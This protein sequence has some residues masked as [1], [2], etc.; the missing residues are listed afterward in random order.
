MARKVG[1]VRFY[2]EP[3]SAGT[4]SDLANKNYPANINKSKLISGNLFNNLNIVQLG[5]QA[6]PG[7]KLYLNRYNSP[8]IIGA[9]GIYELNLEGLTYINGIQFDKTSLDNISNNSN[10]VLIIDYIYEEE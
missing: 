5:I 9:T 7:T 8:I 3:S 2:A 4:S 6:L 10:A 1:Q